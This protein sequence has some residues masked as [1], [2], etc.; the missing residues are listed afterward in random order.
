MKKVVKRLAAGARRPGVLLGITLLA[1]QIGITA[2]AASFAN[3]VSRTR[4]EV[5]SGDVNQDGIADILVRARPAIVML[6]LDD[7]QVPLPITPPSPT[8]VLL[9]GAGGTFTLVS[10]PGADITGS[11]IWQA[12]T[13][14][15]VYG[16]VL[17]TGAGALLIK[18]E[19]S[20]ASSFVVAMAAD[21]GALRLIQQL[22]VATIGINLGAEGTSAE[23]KDT[24]GDGRTDLRVS[25][26]NRLKA[27]L[28]ADAGGVFRVDQGATVAATWNAMLTALD[29]GDKATALRYI[30]SGSNEKYARAFGEM[31]ETARTISGTLSDFAIFELRPRYALASV[32]MNY[33]SKITVRPVTFLYVDEQWMVHEF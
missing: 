23:L 4:Y 25:V 15:V 9:S 29:A 3:A 11:G 32:R 19:N 30:S 31:G 17:G 26:N 16:D 13:H 18:A 7:T 2:Q 24:N 14:R 27:V 21:T 8:F 12:G 20:S 6:N 22:S 33:K 10:K 1:C 5:L 28:V